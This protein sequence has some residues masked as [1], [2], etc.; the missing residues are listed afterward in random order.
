M[1][2]Y[3]AGAEQ[4]IYNYREHCKKNHHIGNSSDISPTHITRDGLTSYR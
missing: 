2:E 3:I 1:W 4:F